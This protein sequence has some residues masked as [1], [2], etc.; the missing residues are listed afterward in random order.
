MEIN[1][2]SKPFSFND[3]DFKRWLKNTSVVAASAAITYVLSN[4][5]PELQSSG[6]SVL[7]V[8]IISTFLNCLQKYLTDTTKP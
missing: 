4:V 1:I 2:G 7:A 5:L 3:A 8:G 6:Y